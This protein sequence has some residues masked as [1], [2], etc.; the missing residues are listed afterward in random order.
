MHAFATW[1]YV[2]NGVGVAEKFLR[3]FW[4]RGVEAFAVETAG[5]R[6]AGISK[7]RNSEVAIASV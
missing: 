2:E 6:S 7:L 3:K 5:V 1:L 4:E